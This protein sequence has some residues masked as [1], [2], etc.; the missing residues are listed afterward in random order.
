MAG[1]IEGGSSSMLQNVERLVLFMHSKGPA[2]HS[3]SVI[4]LA[5]VDKM[6]GAEPRLGPLSTRHAH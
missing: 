3:S 1:N 2:E 5:V 6:N 4:V